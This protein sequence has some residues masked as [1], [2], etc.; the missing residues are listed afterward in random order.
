MGESGPTRIA[1]GRARKAALTVLRS[2]LRSLD[3]IIE[4]NRELTRDPRLALTA[5]LRIADAEAERDLV[6]TRIRMIEDE[7]A[8]RRVGAG[9]DESNRMTAASAAAPT[10]HLTSY[11]STRAAAGPTGRKRRCQDA[12]WPT[13]F[14]LP[15]LTAAD[16]VRVAPLVRKAAN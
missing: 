14:A 3:L 6:R 9:V 8:D 4:H 16:E 7:L 5:L 11:A 10:A 13:T 2:S 1:I 15:E 12:R